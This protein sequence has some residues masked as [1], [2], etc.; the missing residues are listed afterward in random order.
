MND[1][2]MRSELAQK[3]KEAKRTDWNPITVAGNLKAF[4]V[5]VT[6]A[7]LGI[8]GVYE[9]FVVNELRIENNKLNIKIETIEKNIKLSEAYLNLKSEI[10][11]SNGRAEIFG[12][13][14]NVCLT[15]NRKMNGLNYKIKLIESELESCRIS[16][17][18]VLQ[19]KNKTIA[20]LSKDADI[21]AEISALQRTQAD[22]E[23]ELENHQGSAYTSR[24]LTAG[25]K[26]E[27][28]RLKNRINLIQEQ[29]TTL[30]EAL[31]SRG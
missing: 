17:K 23:R 26:R 3:G 19:N 11:I 29:I 20:R 6:G 1:E 8:V 15:E 25:G 5:G 10:S 16:Q 18:S 12:S 24:E 30:T 21:L 7:I 22:V 31:K 28:A 27:E 14:L 9:V 13:Q 4:L 2:S